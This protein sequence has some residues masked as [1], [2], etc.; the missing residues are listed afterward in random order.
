MTDTTNNPGTT[1]SPDGKV[2]ETLGA[3]TV[4]SQ[5]EEQS[6]ETPEA[7][8]AE[9][10][11]KT[12]EKFWG[13]FNSEDDAKKSYEEAQAELTR[14]KQELADLKR[15]APQAVQ[16]QA[17]PEPEQKFIDFQIG[18]QPE[19]K[20]ALYPGTEQMLGGAVDKRLGQFAAQ[21]S[22]QLNPVLAQMSKQIQELQGKLNISESRTVAATAANDFPELKS[23]KGFQAEVEATMKD[24]QQKLQINL[25]DAQ[26]FDSLL[27]TACTAVR[28]KRG[29]E[30]G[31]RVQ[32]ETKAAGQVAMRSMAT[33]QGSEHGVEKSEADTIREGILNVANSPRSNS[34]F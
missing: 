2:Q 15:Q 14:S 29:Y 9:G 30:K 5:S 19:Q 17:Q 10:Q 32:A 31:Q 1:D 22:G 6:S 8:T 4:P 28:G 16:P 12:P 33:G 34:I 21:V 18:E 11:D 13:K 3:F 20:A 26:Q 24:L 25:R 27:R 7:G 23:D